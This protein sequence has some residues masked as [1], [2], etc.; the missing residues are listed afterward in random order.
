MVPGDEI[1]TSSFFSPSTSPII[2]R[3]HNRRCLPEA[4]ETCL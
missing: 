3:L 1:H 4:G 2:S